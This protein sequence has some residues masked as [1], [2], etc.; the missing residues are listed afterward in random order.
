VTDFRD[1]SPEAQRV[2]IALM[3][4]APPWRKVELVGQMY[5]TIKQL[6]LTGLR[7]RHPEESEAK[8]R[9]RLADLL[10]GPEL[11]E[12]AYGPLESVDAD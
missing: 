3:R 2:L 7:Q 12:R 8:L 6:A 10:L 5:I 4:E 1:T 9:R 11:A